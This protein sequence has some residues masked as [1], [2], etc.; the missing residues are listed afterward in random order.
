MNTIHTAPLSDIADILRNLADLLAPAP[1]PA[2]PVQ[3]AKPKGRPPNPR[4]LRQRA[5]AQFAK[6]R[7][8]KQVLHSLSPHGLTVGAS[9]R[10]WAE[11]RKRA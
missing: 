11:H 1:P 3:P 8:R 5:L 10:Y 9:H 4:S 2:K 7:S 6:G